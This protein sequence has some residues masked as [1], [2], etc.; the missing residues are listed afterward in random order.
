MG[1]TQTMGTGKRGTLLFGSFERGNCIYWEVRREETRGK[2]TYLVYRTSIAVTL[3]REYATS[4]EAYAEV[5]PRVDYTGP[6]LESSLG[7]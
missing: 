2:R 1:M 4:E 3:M 5:M 6:T 7:G